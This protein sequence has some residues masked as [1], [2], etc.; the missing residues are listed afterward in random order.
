MPTPARGPPL[1]EQDIDDFTS[2]AALRW[3][4]QCPI[5]PPFAPLRLRW[6]P[7][8]T[9]S[10]PN[11]LPIPFLL[12]HEQHVGE[13]WFVR[14]LRAS[15]AS[16]VTAQ[17][18]GN[19][20]HGHVR[21]SAR[22]WLDF[23]AK[24]SARRSTNATATATAVGLALPPQALRILNHGIGLPLSFTNDTSLAVQPLRIVTLTR[25]N[26]L[27]HAVSCHARLLLHRTGRRP[28]DG[29][30]A[31]AVPLDALREQLDSGMQSY[32][33]LECTAR[34][35]LEQIPSS[36][37][38]G[39]HS[40][41]AR[42]AGVRLRVHYED[43][44]YDAPR[45]LAKVL[46]HLGFTRTEASH[47]PLGFASAVTVSN[48][49]VAGMAAKAAASSSAL[50]PPLEVT[51]A[52][53]ARAP[54]S[55]SGSGSGSG[56]MI[57]LSVAKRAPNSLCVRLINWLPICEAVQGTIWA[58]DL[59]YTAPSAPRAGRT[60]INI[61]GSTMPTVHWDSRGVAASSRDGAS[62]TCGVCEI[63]NAGLVLGG[64]HHKTGTVLL[65][66]LLSMYAS[67]NRVPFHKPSWDSCLP[68]ARREAGVCVDEHLALPMLHRHWGNAVGAAAAL[69]VPLVHVMREPLEACV[70]AYQYHLES[71]EEWLRI[72]RA[73]DYARRGPTNGLP[74]Q[75]VLRGADTRTGLRLEC[76]RSIRDQIAQQAEV[77]NVTQHHARV[78]TLRMEATEADY[79]GSMRALFSFL[80]A[81]HAQW[82]AAAATSHSNGRGK[83]RYTNGRLGTI[84][85]EEDAHVKF[86]TDNA[87]KYDLTR[88]R[89][90]LQDGHLSSV[91]RK[92]Q[93][94]RIILN[95]SKLATELEYW[96]VAAGYDRGYRAH[97]QRY[98][99][100]HFDEAVPDGD[101][102]RGQEKSSCCNAS[103]SGAS[104]LKGGALP[105]EERAFPS[106][107]GA[108]P[109]RV[110]LSHPRVGL[111]LC[112]HAAWPLHFS[113]CQ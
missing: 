14:L 59:R 77:Y 78:F 85:N 38:T 98:R 80:T 1:T 10:E 42:S 92:R 6:L 48:R 111:S 67:V 45:T 56:A 20:A 64:A 63:G 55:G 104:T 47:K 61:I 94:R 11:T 50:P 106:K 96:R 3:N 100:R 75:M 71:A 24:A 82:P 32:S 72:P 5:S 7:L 46:D 87:A 26:R 18:V 17:E 74:W 57:P 53:Q 54:L 69:R 68:L 36:A 12:L 81:A 51:A 37:A 62:S 84:G 49:D 41:N 25:R 90:E 39:R 88:H 102:V 89:R 99:L 97:C 103:G 30:A 9:L 22:R 4:V 60:V 109:P 110:E 76:H 105:P 52:A 34:E 29:T 23:L 21:D 93:L 86:L 31:L 2:E 65:E 35:L 43:L 27:K 58:E 13:A 91:Q 70:S 108:L 19:A 8:P 112:A 16:V 95:E 66:R 113:A 107:G 44:L 101:G 33:I 73:E 79:D 40:T 15:G 28:H 83:S